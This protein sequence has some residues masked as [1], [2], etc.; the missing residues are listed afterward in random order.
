MSPTPRK[1]NAACFLSF[2]DARFGSSYML[3]S[4]GISKGVIKLVR[5]VGRSEAFKGGE[6]EWSGIKV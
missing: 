1:T 5:A 6:I 4:F 3:T 2:A